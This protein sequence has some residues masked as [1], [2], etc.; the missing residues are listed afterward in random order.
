MILKN[1]TGTGQKTV[2]PKIKKP[3]LSKLVPGAG[4]EP[5]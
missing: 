4:I 3:N 2:S 1:G 5:A